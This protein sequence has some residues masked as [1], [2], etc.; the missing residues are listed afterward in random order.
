VVKPS[1]AHGVMPTLCWILKSCMFVGARKS[2][3]G[4][5]RIGDTA[6]N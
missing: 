2:R 6:L 5:D 1:R 3:L 4:L